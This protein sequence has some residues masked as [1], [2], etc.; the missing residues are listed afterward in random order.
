V[1]RD[2]VILCS[3]GTGSQGIFMRDEDGKLPYLRI[4]IENNFI[5]GTNMANGITV[6]HGDQVV[7]RNNTVLSPLDNGN[8]VWIRIGKAGVPNLTMSGNIADTGG[9]KTA[10][11]VL[12]SAQRKLLKKSRMAEIEPEMLTVPGIGWQ[13]R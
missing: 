12:S 5:L 1:V 11:Q 4:T 13:P 2:N 7:I 10:S 9:N 3:N 6:G 8:P